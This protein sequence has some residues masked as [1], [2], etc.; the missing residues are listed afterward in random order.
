LC[1]LAAS[2]D[3]RGATWH[4]L[5]IIFVRLKFRRH[6]SS[7]Y[8]VGSFMNDRLDAKSSQF[9]SALKCWRSLQNRR[10]KMTLSNTGYHSQIWNYPH[11]CIYSWTSRW[12]DAFGHTVKKW[13]RIGTLICI[14]WNLPKCSKSDQ[15]AETQNQTT[16]LVLL[17]ILMTDH[18][19][20]TPCLYLHIKSDIRP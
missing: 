13:Q 17:N 5:T 6:W 9:L 20:T 15:N 1:S 8:T 7:Q 3:N 11:S 12:C 18:R 19:Y 16:L 10:L 2:C 14:L 4:V